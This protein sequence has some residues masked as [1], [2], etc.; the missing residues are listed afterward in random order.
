MRVN[1][2]HAVIVTFSYDSQVSVL[3][4][5]DWE[6]SL[7]FIKNDVEREYNI[8][9]KEN[10]WDSEYV[11]FEDEGRAVLTTHF[12]DRDDIVEWRIGTIFE[13]T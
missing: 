4:F 7:E 1:Y 3:L 12:D 5:E 13:R 9:T 11:I 8:D 10:G 6:R 2:N